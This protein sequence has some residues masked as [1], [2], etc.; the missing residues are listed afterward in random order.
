MQVCRPL[1]VSV[2]VCVGGGGGCAWVILNFAVSGSLSRG[3]MRTTTSFS[4]TGFYFRKVRFST[5]PPL[6]FG[7]LELIRNLYV[8]YTPL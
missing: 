4:I 3:F 1:S 8:C 7:Q 2:C 6:R 5:D